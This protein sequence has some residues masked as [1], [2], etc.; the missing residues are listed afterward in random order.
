MKLCLKCK[1]TLP[2]EEFQFTTAKKDKLRTICIK[3]RA[4]Y[5]K[6]YRDANRKTCLIAE[7]ERRIRNSESIRHSKKKWYLKSEDH[8]ISYRLRTVYGLNLDEYDALFKSQNES[9][10][11]CSVSQD[12]LPKRLC[13][14][15]CHVTGK[16]RGLLC[17]PCNRLLGQAKDSI[18]VLLKAISYLKEANDTTIP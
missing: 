12:E 3:C 6:E 10:K 9:C 5:A 4:K 17:D 13:V 16:V 18:D 8:R 14:D 7:A 1:L 11:I 2:L 15:H